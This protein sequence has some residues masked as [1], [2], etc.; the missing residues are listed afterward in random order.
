MER[1]PENARPNDLRPLVRCIVEL[2]T[3]AIRMPV[4]L[5]QGNRAP[6]ID[7]SCWPWGRQ[8]TVDEIRRKT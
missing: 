6:S 1:G 7:T 3:P 2:P 4:E 5:Q 8:I